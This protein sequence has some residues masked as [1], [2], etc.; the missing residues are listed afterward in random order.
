MSS[1]GGFHSSPAAAAAAV[2]RASGNVAIPTVTVAPSIMGSGGGVSVST[3]L[4]GGSLA[5]VTGS[6]AGISVSAG[7]ATGV[8]HST[9]LG[10]ASPHSGLPP[11]LVPTSVSQLL[12]QTRAIAAAVPSAAI[13]PPVSIYAPPISMATASSG[14]HHLPTRPRSRN[15]PPSS[16]GKTQILNTT[17]M[18][19]NFG[20][21]KDI[22]NRFCLSFLTYPIFLGGKRK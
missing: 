21:I 6:G 5:S 12:A 19:N 4:F 3:S 8:H 22:E 14:M 2:I 9:V 17:L 20:K 15:T 7:G 13:S 11:A 1:I 16:S 18:V 10:A